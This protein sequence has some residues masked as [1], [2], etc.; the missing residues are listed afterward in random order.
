M[1]VSGSIVMIIINFHDIPCLVL[2]K[3]I[4]NVLKSDIYALHL[5][6]NLKDKLNAVQIQAIDKALRT[7]FHLIQG[8][9]G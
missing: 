4:N 3:S 9:P 8:P 2:E 1:E 6:D 5:W 7:N